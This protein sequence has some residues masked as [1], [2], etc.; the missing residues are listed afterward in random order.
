MAIARARQSAAAAGSSGARAACKTLEGFPTIWEYLTAMTFEDGS[1]RQTS[2]LSVFVEDGVVKVA[3][4]D[5][6]EQ[7]S[8]YV[9]GDDLRAAL[10]ALEGQL[11]GAG[12][13]WRAWKV[14]GKKK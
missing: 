6:A 12:A 7:R 4:N 8:A 2:S 9:T 13:D 11:G 10:K 1:E 3:L 14:K 5:R